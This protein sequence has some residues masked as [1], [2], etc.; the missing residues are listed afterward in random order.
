MVA[1]RSPGSNAGSLPGRSFDELPNP[2]R[3]GGSMA[4]NRADPW[5]IYMGPHMIHPACVTE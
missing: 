3:R 2:L 4:V 1:I 5:R